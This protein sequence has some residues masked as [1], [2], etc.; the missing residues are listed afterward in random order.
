MDVIGICSIII[1]LCVLIVTIISMLLSIRPIVVLSLIVDEFDDGAI[2][3][4]RVLYL[5]VQ[6]VGNRTADNIKLL[7]NNLP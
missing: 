3:S 7:E 6:N 1:A 4:P 2:S 5:K